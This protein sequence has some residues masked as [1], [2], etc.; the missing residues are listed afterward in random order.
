MHKSGPGF[1][2]EPA[3]AEP[4]LGP[5]ALQ[6][7]FADAFRIRPGVF[8]ADMLLS[9]GLGW[10]AFFVAGTSPRGSVLGVVAGIV[11]CVALYRAVLFIHELAHLK[12][13]ALRGFETV[14]NLVV[15]I[16]LGVPSLMYV[17]THADHHRNALYGTSLDPEYEP[18]AYWSPVRIALASLG[19]VFV[20]LLLVI[21]WGVVGPL[22][23]LVPP[24]R[25]WAV[26]YASTLVINVRYRREYPRNKREVARFALQ[27]M[28]AAAL[29]WTLAYALWTGALS[30]H[31]ALLWWSMGAGVL[32]L[33][34]FRT[35]AAHRYE[36]H[37]DPL[38]RESQLAD[39][40]NLTGDGLWTLL[41]APVGLRFH[42]LHHLMPALPYHSL[43]RVHRELIET[44]PERSIYRVTEEW[45]VLSTLRALFIRTAYG[46]VQ[47]EPEREVSGERARGEA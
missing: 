25:D 34:Q 7:R 47:P 29:V 9:A 6:R 11:A 26:T 21:R 33:N 12:R 28:G 17:G 4:E 36:S 39:S 16:P 32:V 15:G 37:G 43:G 24:L 10:S 38:D 35:L 41:A 2:G 22:S 19:V 40:V 3:G 45:S 44:L 30:P 42:A 5:A 27:E 13:G 8:W 1:V 31:W 46:N 23:Y 20:P 18:M 14:W